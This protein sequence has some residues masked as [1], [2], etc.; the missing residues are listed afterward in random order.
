MANFAVWVETRRGRPL[1]VVLEALGQARRLASQ[2]G[3]TLYAIVTREDRPDEAKEL[4]TLLGRHGADRVVWFSSPALGERDG[5]R[6]MSHGPALQAFVDT[7]QPALFLFPATPNG[8]ELGRRCAAR[9]SA[10]LLSDGGVDVKDDALSLTDRLDPDSGTAVTFSEPVD[11]P[12]VA[13]VPPGRYQAVQGGDDCEGELVQL[14]EPSND[15]MLVEELS[16]SPRVKVL[17]GKGLSKLAGELA[18]AL[19]GQTKTGAI[20]W[21]IAVGEVEMQGPGGP[22]R[23]QLGGQSDPKAAY[24]LEGDPK[25]HATALLKKLRSSP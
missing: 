20:E 15:L 18:N 1:P 9:S 17:A 14:A 3:A 6:W 7:F 2:L 24:R 10:A 5:A 12:V 8:R 19:G 22:L 16:A 21:L 4:S 11:F 25:E 23:V 13:L